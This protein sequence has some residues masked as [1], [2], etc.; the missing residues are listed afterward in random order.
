MFVEEAGIES[1]GHYIPTQLPEGYSEEAIIGTAASSGKVG[2]AIL[3]VQLAV[4]LLVKGKLDLIMNLFLYLQLI[5]A[6]T[7]YDITIPANV[8]LALTELKKLI[9]FEALKPDRLLEYVQGDF[10]GGS[11]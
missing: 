4:Q 6:T 9:E 5:S 3:F 11:S 2:L 8:D 1:E 7:Q 10:G